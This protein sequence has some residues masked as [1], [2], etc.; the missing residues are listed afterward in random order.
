ASYD[1]AGPNGFVL[2]GDANRDR[3]VDT[4]DFNILA[5]N[6]SQSGK[7]F[8]QSDFNYDGTVDSVDFNLLAS[9]FSKAL[10][11]PTATATAFRAAPI[12]PNE[13]LVA[14]L[15]AART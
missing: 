11:P 1:V 13:G 7:S 12:K 2:T 6:F 4:I 9:N 15:D 14:L 10:A 3:T 5:A 8:G